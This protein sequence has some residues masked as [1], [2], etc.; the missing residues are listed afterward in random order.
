MDV[1]PSTI[2]LRA[3]AFAQKAASSASANRIMQ[4]VPMLTL[5][6]NIDCLR[7][8]QTSNTFTCEDQK[9][10]GSCTPAQVNAVRVSMA[11]SAKGNNAINIPLFF[12]KLAGMPSMRIN[13]SAVGYVGVPG[14]GSPSTGG[15]ELPLSMCGQYLG[16]PDKSGQA[17]AR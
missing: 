9:C 5:A 11:D 6:N 8:D 12:G 15:A 16:D 2:E 10:M 7:Y 14:T 1:S 4:Q 3:A 13:V 17:E